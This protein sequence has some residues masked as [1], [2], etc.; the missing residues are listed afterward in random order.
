MMGKDKLKTNA[1][2]MST[3]EQSLEGILGVYGIE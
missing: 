1:D 2:V 3:E